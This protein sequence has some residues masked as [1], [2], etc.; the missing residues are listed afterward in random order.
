MSNLGISLNNFSQISR[1]FV[2]TSQIEIP[3]VNRT[4]NASVAIKSDVLDVRDYTN[5]KGK[6]LLTYVQ[7]K[8]QSCG[9]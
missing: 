3:A 8:S 5:A 4:E 6:Q 1:F 2:E 9:T 7:S